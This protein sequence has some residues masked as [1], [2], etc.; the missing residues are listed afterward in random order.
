M[1]SVQLKAVSK[2]YDDKRPVIHDVDLEIGDGEFIVLVGPS[3]CGKSTLLRMIAGLEDISGGELRIGARLA[4]HL[5]PAQRQLAMVFQS[6]A[7]YPHMTVFE[8]MAFALRL[9]GVKGEEL[10]QAVGRAADILQITDLL[11][12]RPKELS[13]GQRQRVA[14]G[15]AIVRK[16]EVFLFDEPL[17]NLDASLRVQMRVE[18]A[19]L[20]RELG[21]T[22]IYVTHD[23]VEAMT[24][25]QR[26]VVINGGRIEQVGTPHQLYNQPA[27]LFV[28]GFLG[29]PKMNFLSAEMVS[30]RDTG[31][32]VRLLD[33]TL[34]D[35]AVDA[36]R[37][38]PGERVTVGA[39][40]EHMPL[41]AHGPNLIGLVLGHVEYLGDQSVAYASM[42]GDAALVA[43][44]QS[45][46]G[47]ALAAGMHVRAH[48]P[49]QRCH[50]FDSA[51]KACLVASLHTVTNELEIRTT[52]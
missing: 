44:K 19:R 1:A 31:A 11:Q 34:I 23:Q 30:A 13:G 47:Q 28:A 48:L 17:S 24:L 6:Y 35:I 20:H 29:A 52:K 49:A 21:T 33:G 36:T 45:V 16:P 32:Q 4:N 2:H 25:G 26:I 46:D 15:R 38:A 41:Q 8:N 39:R 7:L 51:G 42:P 9:A 5:P 10:K 18:L 43:V 50:L 3:G 14:I 22:M 40:P 12:R 27:N 37:I